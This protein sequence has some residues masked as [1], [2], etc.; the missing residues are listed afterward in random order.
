MS[1]EL[2]AKFDRIHVEYETARD[3]L[4]TKSM[5]ERK[6]KTHQNDLSSGRP[7]LRSDIILDAIN[8]L[9][10]A[11]ALILIATAEAFMREYLQSHLSVSP[12]NPNLS[13]LIKQYRI[14]FNKTNPT[15]K[16]TTERYI[17]FNELREQRNNYAHGIRTK[18]FLPVGK[19]VSI[20]GKFFH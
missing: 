3:L 4:N 15:N 16:I 9:N 13:F 12:R 20:L 2:I 11:Y 14:M 18:V 8:T 19:I 6:S 17:E 10:D 5:E 7:S 1:K